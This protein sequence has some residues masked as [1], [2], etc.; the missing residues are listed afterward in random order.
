[1]FCVMSLPFPSFTERFQLVIGNIWRM[2]AAKGGR[3]HKAGPLVILICNRLNRISTRLVALAARF[4][5]GT[6][7]A[8]REPRVRRQ[9]AGLARDPAALRLP[10]LPRGFG[11]LLKEVRETAQLGGQVSHI[12]DDPEMLALLAAA[13]QAGRILR[14]LFR[15]M[16]IPVPEAFKL[17]ARPPPRR[18]KP[19]RAARAVVTA[20]GPSPGPRVRA[21]T[22]WPRMRSARWPPGVG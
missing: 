2:V 20:A 21:S 7:P 9:R 5:A 3:D 8:A 11:W 4:K 17:P 22:K 12:L 10:R 13:P 1:M 16:A 14:P 15:M 19:R 18:R 6:L